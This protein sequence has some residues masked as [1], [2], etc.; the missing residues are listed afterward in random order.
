MAKRV[1]FTSQEERLQRL[2]RNAELKIVA[3][4]GMVDTA[5]R[6]IS[7]QS[8]LVGPEASPQ[9]IGVSEGGGLE[10][11]SGSPMTVLD[12]ITVEASHTG[13]TLE[14]EIGTLIV[15]ADEMGP[16]GIVRI[17]LMCRPFTGAILKVYW[18]Q[19]LAANR[20]SSW[21]H[22]A[23]PFLVYSHPIH[24]WNKNATNAQSADND[25]AALILGQHWVAAGVPNAMTEDT[26]A[27]VNIHITVQNAAA[28]NTSN[29]YMAIAEAIHRD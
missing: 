3:L 8:L 28:G 21:T 18:G 14:T 15:P 2:I 13:D 23:A 7:A 20:I 12:A 22:A 29:L 19:I 11:G 17:S 5:E 25:G 24:V 6:I 4:K 26:T 1:P 16:N 10:L 27:D 9:T